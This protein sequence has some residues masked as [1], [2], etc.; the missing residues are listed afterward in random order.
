MKPNKHPARSKLPPR[1][2]S[3]A[4]SWLSQM[5]LGGLNLCASLLHPRNPRLVQP[6]AIKSGETSKR[7][8]GCTTTFLQVWSVSENGWRP[9]LEIW[10]KMRSSSVG[11]ASNLRGQ[12]APLLTARPPHMPL[13]RPTMNVKFK[14]LFGKSCSISFCLSYGLV[15]ALHFSEITVNMI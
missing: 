2:S 3:F 9:I 14:F 13:K 10:R 6:W 15:S 7:F 12:S 5:S 4:K 1:D 8:L 11:W